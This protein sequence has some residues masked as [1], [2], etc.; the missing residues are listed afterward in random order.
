MWRHP[1]TKRS[2]R[3]LEEEWGVDADGEDGESVGE[4][5]FE[6]LRPQEKELACGDVSFLI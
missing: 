2:L 6:V 4:G 3:V 1:V 5:W